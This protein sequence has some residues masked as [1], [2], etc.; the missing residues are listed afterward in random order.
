[1]EL[2]LMGERKLQLEGDVESREGF[3]RCVIC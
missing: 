1:M 3:V 2:A